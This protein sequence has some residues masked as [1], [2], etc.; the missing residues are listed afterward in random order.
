MEDKIKV[1]RS[2]VIY[3][4]IME[5]PIDKK[6]DIYRYELMKP[7]EQKFA[8]YHC[9]LKAK[10]PGGYDV[11]MASGM[12]GNLVPQKIDASIEKKY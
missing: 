2:D 7:F 5:A 12:F 11:V 8:M 10:Q 9:P 1:V 3:R 4:K 6:D